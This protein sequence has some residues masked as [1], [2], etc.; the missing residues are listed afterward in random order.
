MFDN[1]SASVLVDGRPVSLGL[2]DTAGQ[3]DYEWVLIL[4]LDLNLNH[5]PY[6]PHLFKVTNS[7]NPSSSELYLTSS[8]LRPLSYPQTDVFLVCFSVVSPPSFENIRTASLPHFLY[9]IRDSR[10]FH[11]LVLQ[12]NSSERA[13][14][15]TTSSPTIPLA[16][17][18]LHSSFLTIL[19]VLS[20]PP[21]PYLSS[22]H[23]ADA[24][25]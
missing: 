17:T 24:R 5:Y 2:W 11:R 23:S 10:F 18:L 7:A 20:Y 8:R 1:Y 12:Q 9:L 22:N 21:N 6:Y 13:M 4:D 15:S 25:K 19:S 16:T 14:A 3:E